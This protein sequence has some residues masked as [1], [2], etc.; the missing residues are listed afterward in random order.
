V[1]RPKPPA[2]DLLVEARRLLARCRAQFKIREL[3]IEEQNSWL[4]PS[5]QGRPT[6]EERAMTVLVGDINKFMG[7]EG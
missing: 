1:T 5:V 3:D 2:H 6:A 7:D 4:P